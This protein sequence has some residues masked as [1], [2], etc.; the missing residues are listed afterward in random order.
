VIVPLNVVVNEVLA[1]SSR[2]TD[3]VEERLDVS[4]ED[5]ATVMLLMIVPELAVTKLDD[6]V[7]ARERTTSALLLVSREVSPLAA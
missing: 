3:A 4:E 6:A 1:A 7:N 2:V 5:A